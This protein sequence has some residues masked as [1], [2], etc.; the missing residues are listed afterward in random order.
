MTGCD[1]WSII[2]TYETYQVF[3]QTIDVHMR[4]PFFY[5]FQKNNK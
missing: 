2:F 3:Y 1:V 4:T 5:N